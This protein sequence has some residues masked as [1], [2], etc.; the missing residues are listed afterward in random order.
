LNA[1][2]FS[3][4]SVRLSGPNF[5]TS[6][7]FLIDATGPRGFLHRTLAPGESSFEDFPATGA[8]YAHFD[9][10]ARWESLPCYAGGSPPYPVDDAA[11][12]HIFTGGW[13]WVL[14]FN[15]GLTSAGVATTNDVKD[16]AKSW[17]R[18]LAL[19]PSLRQQFASAKPVSPFFHLPRVPFRS[20][21]AAGAR[22]AMLPSAAGS[23]DP[24][25]ST[26]FPLTL[27]GVSRLAKIIQRNFDASALA[28]YERLTFAE[29]DRTANLVAQ[30]YSHFDDFEKFSAV[31]MKYFAA[32]SYAE[33]ARRL[34]RPDKTSSFLSGIDDPI[35]AINVAG[36]D[37][38]A[39]RNWYPCRAADLLDHCG[40]LGVTRDEVRQMLQRIG[41]GP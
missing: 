24:L 6:A 30:L 36:L 5:F 21:R 14:R 13:I 19:L 1:V 31:A 32:A 17:A 27:L 37:D 20:A 41:F 7:G 12:H 29:L 16:G 40:K 26:G 35:D 33:A 15:N 39:R 3:G 34:N 22:W 2:E 11:Q 9:G 18:L 28:E 4:D 25:L 8:L 10:A 38:P 23:I